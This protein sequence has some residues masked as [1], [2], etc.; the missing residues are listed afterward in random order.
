M[1]VK[2]LECRAGA[3]FLNMVGD[4]VEVDTDEAQRMIDAGQAELAVPEK[5]IERA[6]K[7]KTKAKKK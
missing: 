3:D 6:T 4:V 5:K 7:V 1:K 2:M